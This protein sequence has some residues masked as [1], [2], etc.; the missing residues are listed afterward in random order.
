MWIW[1]AFQKLWFR[2]I[3]FVKLDLIICKAIL[4]YWYYEIK[5]TLFQC[6]KSILKMTFMQYDLIRRKSSRKLK[7]IEIISA[8]TAVDIIWRHNSIVT[9]WLAIEL[10]IVSIFFFSVIIW[11]FLKNSGVASRVLLKQEPFSFENF[12]LTIF[13]QNNQKFKYILEI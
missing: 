2:T 4:S 8:K 3:W 9:I 13:S 1:M 10:K 7:F 5:Q 12:T 6:Y 11:L